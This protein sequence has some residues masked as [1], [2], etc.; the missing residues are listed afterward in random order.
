M[1][2]DNPLIFRQ[3]RWKAVM[4]SIA[5]PLMIAFSIWFFAYFFFFQKNSGSSDLIVARALGIVFISFIPLWAL[6]LT[7]TADIHVDNDG[8]GRWFCGKRLSYVPWHDLKMMTIE[9]FI[10]QR[11]VITCYRLFATEER[12]FINFQLHGLAFSD[13]TLDS[14]QLIELINEQIQKYNVPVIDHR[15]GQDAVNH[16]NARLEQ[17]KHESKLTVFRVRSLSIASRGAAL[18]M[19]IILFN[20]ATGRQTEFSHH[21]RWVEAFLVFYLAISFV[22][23]TIWPLPRHPSNK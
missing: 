18:G 11:K 1:K 8:I 22:I 21:L 4:L 19:V 6:A 10:S 16:A 15:P 2:T 3:E 13:N 12:N 9:S 14:K 23:N 20:R 5:L 17:L 7:G